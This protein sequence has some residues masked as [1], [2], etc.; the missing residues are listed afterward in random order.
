MKI[1]VIICTFLILVAGL[2]FM[3][4]RNI[5][6]FSEIEW[7]QVVSGFETQ[8]LYAE[9]FKDGKYFN[10]WSRHDIRFKDLFSW[11]L[12]VKHKYSSEEKKFMPEIIPDSL[13]RLKNEKSDCILWMGHQSFLIQ[14]S[15]KLFLFDP[16]L[17]KRALVPSRRI[18]PALT[19]S[20]LNSLNREITVFISHSHYDH[21]DSGTIKKLKIQKIIVPAG[22]GEFA[23]KIN[24]TEVVEL[25]WW[26]E[27]SLS[28]NIILTSLPAQHWSNRL[29]VPE[30]TSLWCNYLLSF[31]K[32]VIFL[33]GDSGYFH[34]FKEFGKKFK[35]DIAVFSV[36]A[37]HPRWFMHYSHMNINESLR[38]FKDMKSAKYILGH[39][40]TFQLADEPSGFPAL[41]LKRKIDELKLE[42]NRYKIPAIGEIILIK[43]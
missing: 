22:L 30:D 29:D 37:Y 14:I 27:L 16:V 38:A 12:S 40:G 15:G 17:T 24:D 20:E 18:P 21:F 11:K 1:I 26:Q 33:G 41:E 7:E 42:K 36:S 6:K 25:N 23:K 8:S 32:A 13:S 19:I 4:A 2:I 5:K 28:N 31:P 43:K 35:I 39:W 3:N 34:G 10:P 9:N